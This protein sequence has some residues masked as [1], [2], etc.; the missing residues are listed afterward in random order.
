M[1][2]PPL[3]LVMPL[4]FMEPSVQLSRPATL[5]VPGPVMPPPARFRVLTEVVL[6]KLTKPF[7]VV[8]KVETV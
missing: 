5:S 3:A 6:G 2:I 1:N 7:R 8:M 4:P